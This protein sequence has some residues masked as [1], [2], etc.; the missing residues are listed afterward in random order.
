MGDGSESKCEG[1]NL[2]E[3]VENER[4]MR[5]RRGSP[6]EGTS[7]PNIASY[8]NPRKGKYLT[9]LYRINRNTVSHNPP[10]EPAAD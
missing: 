4:N 9:L 2:Q 10:T 8:I 1:H 7:Q 6:R 5:R 3:P